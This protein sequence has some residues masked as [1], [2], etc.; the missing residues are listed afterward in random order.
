[1]TCLGFLKDKLRL[2]KQKHVCLICKT[3][4]V[5]VENDLCDVCIIKLLNGDFP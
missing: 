3:P 4:V 2:V 1:M 5:K